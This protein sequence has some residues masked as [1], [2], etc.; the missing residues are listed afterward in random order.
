MI[1]FSKK[2]DFNKTDHFFERASHIIRSSKL[3]HYAKEGVEALKAATPVDSGL[4]RDKWNYKI[5]YGHGTCT[6]SFLNSNVHEG[7]LIA[8]ILQHGH[9]TGTGGFVQGTD[10]INPAIKPVFDRIA[11]EAWKEVTRS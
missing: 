9:G 5:E 7:V 10:Y 3:D 6:I 4:T 11:D 1:S 2:G 8:V